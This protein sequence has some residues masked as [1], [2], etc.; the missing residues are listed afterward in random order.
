MYV[1]C[2]CRLYSQI[3]K[4][5]PLHNEWRDAFADGRFHQR[6]GRAAMPDDGPHAGAAADGTG[7]DST[8][9]A[10]GAAQEAEPLA[11]VGPS[12]VSARR[13]CAQ[14]AA[15]STAPS[16]H[17][18][19][20][21]FWL[22]PTFSEEG[23]EKETLDLFNNAADVMGTH[24]DGVAKEPFDGFAEVGSSCYGENTEAFLLSL[25]P[26]PKKCRRA[27][28]DAPTAVPCGGADVGGSLQQQPCVQA[29]AGLLGA[30]SDE[31]FNLVFGDLA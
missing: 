29:A 3:R 9:E 22:D 15:G 5:A 1:R 8:G 25:L 24:K 11:V 28:L 2:I 20:M 12:R 16:P 6:Q 30:P 10:F 7:A 21:T 18:S 14:S 23:S 13:L 4:G 26:P 19:S 31:L 27:Y 17:A